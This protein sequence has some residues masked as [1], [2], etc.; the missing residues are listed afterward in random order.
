MERKRLVILGSTGSVGKQ[1]LE[2][3]RA[4]PN[5]FE[6]IG[7]AADKNTNLL[8]AQI[9]EFKPRMVFSA[10]HPDLFNNESRLIATNP[11]KMA[12]DE[13]TDIVMISTTGK[14][15]LYPT[16]QALQAGKRVCLANKEVIIMAG[17]LITSLA[18]M[19]GELF[20][21]DSEPNAIWQCMHGEASNPQRIIITASGGP[22]RGIPQN[23][24]H[25]VTPDQALKHPTWNMGP[26]ITV[27]SSTLMNKGFEVIEAKWLFNVDWSQIEVVIHP[28]SI[29]HSMVEF[30]DGS[31]KAQL[32][33]PDMKLPIQYALLFPDRRFNR[34][35]PRLDLST[36]SKM[37]FESLSEENYPCYK[38][39]IEAGRMGKTYP[40]VLC[41]SDEIAVSLFLNKKLRFTD[42]P[43]VVEMSL[44][45]HAPSDGT[46]LEEIFQVDMLARSKALKIAKRFI[47]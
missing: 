19:N 14:A 47:Q 5:N 20:P 46:D 10:S 21:V 35:I 27:D 29:I 32:A 44:E 26:R 1:T 37:T 8:R 30:D 18:N 6:V 9:D 16:V 2:I 7:L 4:F 33:V 45:A 11:D 41:A 25:N 15:G 31:I 43:K 24:L 3:V 40:V 23:S 28:Q 36:Q 13:S 22:F 34:E 42:I 17:S 39:A 38:H 12:S